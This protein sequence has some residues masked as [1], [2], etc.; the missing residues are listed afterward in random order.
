MPGKW[1]GK[2]FSAAA[3]ALAFFVRLS[4]SP[5]LALEVTGG[6]T[7]R[8]SRDKRSG[9]DLRA[10]LTGCDGG[11]DEQPH[12]GLFSL[13]FPLLSPARPKSRGR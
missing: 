1:P 4:R 6:S 8:K 3:R 7:K 13:A 11:I 12:E 10:G 2:L 9:Y 5:P